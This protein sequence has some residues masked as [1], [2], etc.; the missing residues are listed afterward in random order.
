[1]GRSRKILRHWRGIFWS[2]DIEKLDWEKDKAYIIHQV[3][4]YGNLEDIKQLFQI[5]SP[6]EIQTTFRKEPLK[7]YTPQAFNFVK[8]FIVGLRKENLPEEK[9]V[10]TIYDKPR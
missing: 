6:E 9:Y 7:I 8:N 5:Y 2:A 3:L 1:M 4:M 10:S